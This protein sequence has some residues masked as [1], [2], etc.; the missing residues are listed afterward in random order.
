MERG[1]N[2]SQVTASSINRSGRRA[3][4]LAPLDDLD[5]GFDGPGLATISEDPPVR[6]ESVTHSPVA[7][8][9]VRAEKEQQQQ[10]V[11]GDRMELLS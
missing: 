6:E 4:E 9:A 1:A 3:S 8:V 11:G 5:D 10:Q 2:V 7:A